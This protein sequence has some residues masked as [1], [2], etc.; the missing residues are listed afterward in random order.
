[1]GRQQ[2]IFSRLV[3]RGNIV[4]ILLTTKINT[5]RSNMVTYVINEIVSD[6]L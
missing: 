6:S 1:M 5:E 2:L 4:E 3:I